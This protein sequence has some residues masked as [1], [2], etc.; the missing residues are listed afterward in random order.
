MTFPLPLL[1]GEAR[2]EGIVVGCSWV[3]FLGLGLWFGW[4]GVMARGKAVEALLSSCPCWGADHLWAIVAP[5]MGTL[6]MVGQ[7]LWASLLVQTG[8]G[9]FHVFC[10]LT[11]YISSVPLSWKMPFPVLNT[12][13][14]LLISGSEE[15]ASFYC[16][17]A[18]Y[19]ECF[20]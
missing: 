20:C 8:G 3:S 5:R 16:S 2:I 10:N 9:G 14:V 4:S 7:F 1:L 13:T 15:K 18:K 6:V 17:L 12:K 19:T 11:D